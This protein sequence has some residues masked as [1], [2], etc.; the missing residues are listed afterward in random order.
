MR[1]NCWNDSTEFFR[2]LPQNEG[3]LTTIQ[4][5]CMLINCSGTMCDSGITN[6]YR[7]RTVIEN[8]KFL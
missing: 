6:H 1:H 5:Q 3:L 4:A 7:N 2:V 8:Y